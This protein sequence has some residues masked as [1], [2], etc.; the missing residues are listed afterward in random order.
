MLI[1]TLMLSRIVSEALTSIS[2][3]HNCK[4]FTKSPPASLL[5]YIE[6]SLNH[7][8]WTYIN[9]LKMATLSLTSQLAL[10]CTIFIHLYQHNYQLEKKT[11][12]IPLLIF[13]LVQ[14]IYIAKGFVYWIAI[15]VIV[16]LSNSQSFYPPVDFDKA[17]WLL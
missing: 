10:I 4:T 14:A 6:N 13:H 17:I 3:T 1:I 7:S 12:L 8:C 2:N 16:S 5:H 9:S 15:K 11:I